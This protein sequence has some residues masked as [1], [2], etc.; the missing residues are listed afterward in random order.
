MARHA[1]EASV[2]HIDTGYDNL[3]MAGVDRAEAVAAVAEQ[4][5]KVLSAWRGGFAALD[6]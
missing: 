3:L 2:R 1:V 4:V 6:T 5:E